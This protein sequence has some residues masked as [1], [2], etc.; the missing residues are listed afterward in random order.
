MRSGVGILWGAMLALVLA[1]SPGPAL[2]FETYGAVKRALYEEVFATNRRTLYC[3]CPFNAER[4]P[5][6]QACGYL[7]PGGGKRS[8]RI[9]VEHVIPASWIG[10]GRPCW[11]E[12]ICRNSHGDSFKG[13]KCCLQIDPGFRRAYM[14]LTN[15]WPTI[16]EVNE[17][18]SNYPFGLIEGERRVFGR[19]DVEIER[20]RRMVE[21][22]PEMRGDIARIGLYMEAVHGIR[23]SAGQRRLFQDWHRDDPPDAEERQR[24]TIIKDLQGRHNPWIGDPPAM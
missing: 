17:V 9:E 13:R 12:K 21:P 19:C 23:L 2:A 14:D 16:G 22:R 6:L 3:G 18:R 10:A 5:D 15:L 7:S 4:R 11:T 20:R 24:H 8:K 1:W